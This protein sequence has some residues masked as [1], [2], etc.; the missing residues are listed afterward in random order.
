MRSETDPLVSF[1][2]LAMLSTPEPV[3]R[4]LK[5][6]RNVKSDVAEL[7]MVVALGGP[8]P[9]NDCRSYTLLYQNRNAVDTNSKSL[10][11]L[12]TGSITVCKVAALDH[13]LLDHSAGG[14][15]R[16]SGTAIETTPRKEKPT[17][18]LIPCS[19]IPP[20]QSRA[21]ESCWPSWEQSCRTGLQR[22]EHKV[23]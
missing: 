14:C 19:R 7:G 12:S 9:R 5:F 4:S 3:W 21:H 2:A 8:R 17:G 15:I 18:T 20:R 22:V 16:R 23:R 11:G 1:P 10:H 6:Y 13:K